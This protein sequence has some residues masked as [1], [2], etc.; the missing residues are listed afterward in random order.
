[1]AKQRGRIKGMLVTALATLAIAYVGLGAVM[2]FF[3]GMFLFMPTHAYGRTPAANR[4]DYEEVA[5]EVDG[6]STVGWFI[7]AEADPRGVIL[8]SHGNAGNMADRLESVS[9]FRDL[10][11]SVLV[12]DYGGYG[13]ST[14]KPSEQRCY[15][16][17]RAMWRYLCEERG[18]DPKEI[19]LF[20][21]S[22]GSGPTSQLATEVE[23]A[24][25]ILESAFL[26]VV[27][28]AQELY[29]VYPARLMV[30]HR[31][32]NASKVAQFH[33]PLLVVHSPDDSLIPFRHG[34]ELFTLAVEPKTFLEIR[35]DH[36]EGFWMSGDLYTE[37][38]NAFLTPLVAS[39]G[40]GGE[41][42]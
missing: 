5:L 24:A 23:P 11:F 14:G 29:R 21:R 32:D 19:V 12:Y 6:E 3:Q 31:F 41:D 42:G 39:S 30:R 35:G 20:G 22:V 9:I 10:G 36:N 4:W 18:L 33:A 17:I 7:P 1:M 38:L 8:F 28:M 40:T 15:A 25:V 26:S 16:D 37:G 27:R 2:Y 34:H 13:E